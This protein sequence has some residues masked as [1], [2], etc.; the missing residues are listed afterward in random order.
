[1]AEQMLEQIGHGNAGYTY[2]YFLLFLRPLQ[3]SVYFYYGLSA[4]LSL[5]NSGEGGGV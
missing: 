2:I 5:A 3:E 1:M 4:G